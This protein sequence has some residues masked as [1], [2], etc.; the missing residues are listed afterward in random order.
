M[1]IQFYSA[2]FWG[3]VLSITVLYL[4]REEPYI[5][6]IECKEVVSVQRTATLSIPYC[7][8]SDSVYYQGEWRQATFIEQRLYQNQYENS[9]R[10]Y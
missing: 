6:Q 7:V 9:R 8:D 2:I 4:T 3:V 10:N 5:E 1:K